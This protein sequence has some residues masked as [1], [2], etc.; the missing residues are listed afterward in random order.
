MSRAQLQIGRMSLQLPAGFEHRGDGIARRLADE[1]ARLPVKRS[2]LKE[3][4]TLAPLQLHPAEA[5]IALASRIA[6]ALHAHIHKP[7]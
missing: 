4:V 2:L 5:D 7:V 3:R 1:L 6:R